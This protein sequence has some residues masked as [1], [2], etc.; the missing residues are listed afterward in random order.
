[1]DRY[2][3]EERK[4]YTNKW[5]Q[6]RKEYAKNKLGAVCQQCGSKEN[7]EFDHIDP[8]T[9][10]TSIAKLWTASKEKFEAELLKCQLLCKSC[11]YIKT[12]P[13]YK[14]IAKNLNIKRYGNKNE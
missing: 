14:E 7:L 6:K 10:I 4:N 2:S 5:R 9:K 8:N 3:K 1:M 11:H 13:K 12:L